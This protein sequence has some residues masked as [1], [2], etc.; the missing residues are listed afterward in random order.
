MTK[1]FTIGC[2]QHA[3]DNT[4][5]CAEH[6]PKPATGSTLYLMER[7]Q[8]KERALAAESKLGVAL[9]LLAGIAR[10]T[11]DSP[12][13]RAWDCVADLDGYERLGG[14]KR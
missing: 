2:T 4:L 10:G 14:P 9:T 13:S 11:V 8:W 5:W 6:G 7:D 1:C 3:V 12:G